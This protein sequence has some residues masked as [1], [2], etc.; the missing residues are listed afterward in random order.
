MLG[1]SMD[2][3]YPAVCM[4]HCCS[5]SAESSQNVQRPSVCHQRPAEVQLLQKMNLSN[6]NGRYLWNHLAVHQHNFCYESR[7]IGLHWKLPDS[8]QK[9]AFLLVQGN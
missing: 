4:S 8:L 7:H 6:K 3:E 2:G 9:Q 1:L 5:F